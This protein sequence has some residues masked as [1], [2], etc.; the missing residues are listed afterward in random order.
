MKNKTKILN[1]I[2]SILVSLVIV[3][4]ARMKLISTSQRVEISS[5]VGELPYMKTLGV[6]EFLLATVFVYPRTMRIGLLLLTGYF[7]GAM[8]VELSHGTVFIFPAAIL[9]LA[10]IGAYLRD[11]SL[12]PGDQKSD[13]EIVVVSKV[14]ESTIL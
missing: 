12:F 14:K 7:G 5:K 13:R 2:T 6:I 9:A 1:W 8:P 11:R 3:M 4:G 10:W